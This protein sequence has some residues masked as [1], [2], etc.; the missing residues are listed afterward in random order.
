MSINV[1]WDVPLSE[2]TVKNIKL[3]IFAGRFVKKREKN[4]CS[5]NKF[6]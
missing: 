6:G 1:L 4:T 5:E 2:N 3:S